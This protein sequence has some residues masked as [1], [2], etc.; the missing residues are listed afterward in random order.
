MRRRKRYS[1]GTEDSQRINWKALERWLEKRVGLPWDD[2]YS[3]LMNKIRGYGYNRIYLIK[4]VVRWKVITKTFMDEDGIIY[5]PHGRR[6]Y[7]EDLYVDPEGILRMVPKQK[8]RPRV[9]PSEF[10]IRIGDSEYVKEKGQWYAIHKYKERII[11]RE[12]ILDA[13]GKPI[14]VFDMEKNKKVP[15]SKEIV[16]Y[17][18]KENRLSLGNEDRVRLRRNG[19]E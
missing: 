14:F 9:N 19:Y 8:R 6:L 2:T 10:R 11:R 1:F 16:T 13:Q 12:L 7:S 3:E 15:L 18:L 4:E 5:K 17:K